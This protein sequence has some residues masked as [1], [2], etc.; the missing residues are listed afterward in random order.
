MTKQT[1][2]IHSEGV[3]LYSLLD[4]NTPEELKQNIDELMNKHINCIREGCELRFD[5]YTY[6]DDVEVT[7]NITRKETNAEYT[8]R[9]AKEKASKNATAEKLKAKRQKEYLKLKAEFEG[10]SNGA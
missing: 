10:E 6:H 3:C 9:L 5:V 7:L 1:L 8:A 4:G 2:L